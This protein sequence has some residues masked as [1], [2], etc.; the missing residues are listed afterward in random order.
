MTGLLI[1]RYY[2]YMNILHLNPVKNS[3]PGMNKFMFLCSADNFRCPANSRF[4]AKKQR[5]K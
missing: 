4:P 3:L 1:F 5:H 2:L